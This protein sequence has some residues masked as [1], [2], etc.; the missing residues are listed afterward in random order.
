MDAVIKNSLHYIGEMDEYNCEI[1]VGEIKENIRTL[2]D[3]SPGID[4]I[5]NAFLK[6][7]PPHIIEEVK[8]M[9]NISWFS[10]KL[11][12]TWKTGIIIPILKPG[13]DQ[14]NIASYRPI[15]LLSCIAKLMEKV[16][17]RRLEYWVEKN[18]MLGKY[19]CGFRKGLSTIDVLLRLQNRIRRSIDSKEYCIVVYL[20]LK[21][22]YD[23][24]WH[25]GQ[26]YKLAKMGIRGNMVR[27]FKNYLSQRKIMVR[28][29]DTLSDQFDITSGVCQGAVVSPLLFNIMLSDIPVEH[30][31]DIYCYA[32]DLTFSTSGNDL[33]ACTRT[34]QRY[35]ERLVKWLE[36]WGLVVSQEKSSMQI[37]TSKRKNQNTIIRVKNQAIPQKKEQRLLGLI[38]DAPNLT[39]KAHINYLIEDIRKRLAIMKVLSSISWGASK[40]VLRNFYIAY[41]RSKMDYASIIY[42]SAAPT[43]LEKLDKLQNVALRLILGA[44]KTSPILSM[45]VEAFIAPLSTRRRMLT[46]KK[47][48]KLMNSPWDNVTAESIDLTNTFNQ[49]NHNPT[50]SFA[51]EVKA[52]LTTIQFKVKRRNIEQLKYLPPWKSLCEYVKLDMPDR[53]GFR[54]KEI[55]STMCELQY[56]NYDKIFTDGS[57]IYQPEV[58]TSSSFYDEKTKQTTNWKLHPD[59]SVLAA[60]LFA[61]KQGLIIITAYQNNTNYVIFTDSRAAASLIASPTGTY[62]PIVNDI[63]ELLLSLNNRKRVAVQWVKGHADIVGNTVADLSAKLGHQNNRSV[64]Y[65]LMLQEL[66]STLKSKFLTYWDEDWK[67]KVEVSNKGLFLRNLIDNIHSKNLIYHKTRRIEVTLSRLRIGHAAVKTTLNRFNLAT[68]DLCINCNVPETI[69]HLILV[70]NKYV[71]PRR[72]LERNLQKVGIN[73]INLKILLGNTNQTKNCKHFILKQ[74]IQFLTATK[75][76]GNL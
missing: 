17:C 69:Q 23:K 19:Q 9:F 13:K 43:V 63:Q 34:M 48:L 70:C 74:L 11:P 22:A 5:P 24:V 18:R 65:P 72:E 62:A 56:N 30:N 31:V 20:D 21:G 38:L 64:V 41:V 49:T 58:S 32:D 37:F 27:W 6:Y 53:V 71:V 61:I 57:K 8:N 15:T 29:G 47:Y 35:I 46:S 55:F 1:T 36:G 59:H 40:K 42:N 45:E 33:S 73:N 68:D 44:W 60:E 7:I 26:L 52:I 2:R 54:D 10:G 25:K 39:Y 76:I 12:D 3:T 67:Y 66:I 75:T 50:R 14:S 28:I 51:A 16:I 4:N